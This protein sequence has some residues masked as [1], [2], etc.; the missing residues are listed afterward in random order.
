MANTMIEVTFDIHLE[1]GMDQED[2]ILDDYELSMMLEHTKGQMNTHIQRALGELHCDV[3]GKSPEVTV[4]GKYSL[5]TEQLDVSYNIDT[6]CKPFLLKS[7][8]ALNRS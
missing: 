6:C 4:V 8:A 1:G 7:I 2:M 5:E 3:H